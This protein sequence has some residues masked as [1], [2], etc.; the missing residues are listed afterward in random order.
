MCFSILGVS[1]VCAVFTKWQRCASLCL[2]LSC[3][4]MY[5]PLCLVIVKGEERK[6]ADM[7]D[8]GVVVGE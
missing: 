5:Y 8:R 1:R 2:N 4:Y 7:A 6:K 3:I